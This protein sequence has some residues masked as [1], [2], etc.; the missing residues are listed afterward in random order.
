M[1]KRDRIEFI[2]SID[3]EYSTEELVK[4]SF[5]PLMALFNT[6]IAYNID[7]VRVVDACQG[8][9][10]FDI[11]ISQPTELQ[12]LFAFINNRAISIYG[13]TYDLI[14]RSSGQA[15]SVEMIERKF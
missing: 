12:N 8:H 15:L 2:K 7:N 11:T 13:K 6:T 5:E 10:T 4:Q 9:H 3:S 14:A 1:Y